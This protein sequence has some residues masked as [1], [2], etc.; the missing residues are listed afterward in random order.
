MGKVEQNKQQKFDNILKSAQT[1]FMSKG[2]LET[3]ISDITSHAGV[4]KGTFY[5]YFKDKYSIRDTLV[6]QW[7]RRLFAEAH[8][9]LMEHPEAASFED[10]VIF[11]ADHVIYELE[12]NKPLLKFI[13][14]NLSWGLFRQL[15]TENVLEDHITGQE[16]FEKVAADCRITLKD[17]EIMLYILIE[18]INSTAYGAIM[19]NE[20]ITLEQLM[21]YLNDSI[22]A[23]IRNHIVE[24]NAEM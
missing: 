9:A 5:L 6:I 21:P 11:I 14:K 24:N 20:Q 3:S 22:R 13:S 16:I 4:A 15:Y 17:P 19:D 23:I 12:K 18:M 7:S 1:L 10:R 8:A 2:L